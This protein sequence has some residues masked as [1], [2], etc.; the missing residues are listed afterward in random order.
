MTAPYTRWRLI[1]SEFS[2]R[3]HP[4][5]QQQPTNPDNENI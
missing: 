1:K 2:R 3:C 5:Y 4:K